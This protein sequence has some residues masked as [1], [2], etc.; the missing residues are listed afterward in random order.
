MSD[1]LSDIILWRK[2][3]QSLLTLLTA[4]TTWVLLQVYQFNFLTLISYLAMFIVASLFLSGNL[5]RL[6]GKGPPDL[7]RVGI[8]EKSASEMGNTIQVWVEEG[9]RWM[10]WVAAEREWFVFVGT[11]S[12]LLLVSRVATSVDL[13]TLLYIGTVT[14]MTVPAMYVKYQDKI[15]RGEEKLKAQLKRYYDT[16]D[17]KVVKKLQN[18]V[19]VREEKEKKVE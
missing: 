3:R 8:S 17:E 18:K 7:S 15:K 9:I 12:G 1:T 14:G 2:K 16:V 10:F 6:L 13:L 4:T 11:V 5:L 19:T